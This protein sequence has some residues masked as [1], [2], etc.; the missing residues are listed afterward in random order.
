MGAAFILKLVDDALHS[1][2]E[3]APFLLV[4]RIRTIGIGD[5]LS[6]FIAIVAQAEG[7]SFFDV[8]RQKLKWSG[9]NV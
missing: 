9:S 5:R 2:K 7:H 1:L 4:Q 6:D 8:L 3:L